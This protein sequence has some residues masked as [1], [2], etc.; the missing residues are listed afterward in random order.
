[1][2]RRKFN[3]DTDVH[4]TQCV[5][6]DAGFN[7]VGVIDWKRAIS[8][9]VINEGKILLA[10]RDGS[11]IRS[12]KLTYPRP[13]V[14]MLDRYIGPKAYK[15]V[16]DDAVV[17]KSMIMIRDN[18]TCYVCGEF[19]D[20]LEHLMP[21]ARGGRTT[22][23]NTAVA[24]FKHNNVKGSKTPQEMGWKWPEI[25]KRFVNRRHEEILEAIY[26]RMSEESEDES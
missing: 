26:E 25:P 23:G 22:W 20:T 11:M 9:V 15:K 24:C 16:D 6:I 1:M 17:S 10:R 4:K 12:E 8:I 3:L 13:A 7:F 21:Q 19:G 5:I 14:V 2:P 18:W